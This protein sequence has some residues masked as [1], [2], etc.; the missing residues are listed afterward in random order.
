MSNSLINTK[1]P[2]PT[3]FKRKLHQYMKNASYKYIKS[4]RI[5]GF[6]D[7]TLFRKRE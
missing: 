4:V 7:F 6:I 2:F 3:I 5:D 1:T